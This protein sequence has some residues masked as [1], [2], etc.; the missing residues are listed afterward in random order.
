MAL[1]LVFE[2]ILMFGGIWT[3]LATIGIWAEPNILH[4][5]YNEQKTLR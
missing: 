3:V 5:G 1:K 4:G 2:T